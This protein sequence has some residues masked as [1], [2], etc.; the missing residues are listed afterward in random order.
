MIN[1]NQVLR[2]IEGSDEFKNFKRENDDSYLCSAFFVVDFESQSETKQ[3]D[4]YIPAK[5][6]IASFLVDGDIKFNIDDVF[7]KNNRPLKEISKNFKIDFS[8]AINIAKENLDILNEEEKNKTGKIGK[9]QLNKII[10]ILQNLN[11]EQIWNLTCMVGGTN[12]ML[13]HIN[14]ENGDV[15]KMDKADLMSFVT[16][17]K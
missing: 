11:E 10:A 5:E 9:L 1:F 8:K 4:Y 2:R 7:Q 17:E 13:I 16:R 12:M 6:K 14:A 15:T 3:M